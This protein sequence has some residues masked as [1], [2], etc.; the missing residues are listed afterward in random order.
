MPSKMNTIKRNNTIKRKVKGKTKKKVPRAR[1]SDTKQV[2]KNLSK[3][4]VKKSSKP[5]PPSSPLVPAL[6]PTKQDVSPDEKIN[7]LAKEQDVKTQQRQVEIEKEQLK[8]KEDLM[9]IQ[10]DTS[11]DEDKKQLYNVYNQILN[12]NRQMKQGFMNLFRNNNQNQ[13]LWVQREPT[14]DIIYLPDK[15]ETQENQLEYLAP[16]PVNQQ[17]VES[18]LNQL[19]ENSLSFENQILNEFKGAKG[20][21]EE[22]KNIRFQPKFFQD[23]STN[24]SDIIKEEPVYEF[25][26]EEKP[27]EEPGVAPGQPKRKKLTL[28]K[29]DNDNNVPYDL[30]KIRS[31]LNSKKLPEDRFYDS[32]LILDRPGQVLN[33]TTGNWVS[34]TNKK[35]KS[36]KKAND[37]TPI[38]YIEDTAEGYYWLLQNKKA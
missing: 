2:T 5:K 16:E 37:G 6:I 35:Y 30:R 7:L 18:E 31:I 21:L 26:E 15:S 13:G 10:Y 12:E 27:K 9:R 23:E 33:T 8:Q 29:Q 38:N 34:I 17:V 24:L 25:I 20:S 36:E 1:L 3:Q 28:I 11:K 22:P 14:P 32:E 4:K 19:P